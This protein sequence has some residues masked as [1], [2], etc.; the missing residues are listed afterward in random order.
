MVPN[1]QW[2]DIE[3]RTSKDYVEGVDAFL[4]YVF[5]ELDARE[6]IRCPCKKCRNTKINT[7][8]EVRLHLFIHGFFSSYRTWRHHVKKR[9]VLLNTN[10]DVRDAGVFDML[11]GACG[12][13]STQSSGISNMDDN[14]EDNNE[15]V[16]N[17]EA[18]TFYELL[19]D[20]KQPIYNGCKDSNCE[21][22]SFKVLASCE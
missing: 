9:P 7:K 8:E 18:A 3:D 11:R 22:A 1:K 10:T 19:N 14:S 12:V 21:T 17:S 13:T 4:N 20:A 5:K 2:M 6:Q 15:H 16:P